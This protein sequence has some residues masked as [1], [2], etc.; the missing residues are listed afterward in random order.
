MM[1]KAGVRLLGIRP[2]MVVA[3]MVAQEVYRANGADLAVTSVIDGT[4]SRASKH[5]TGCGVDL[6]TRHL[7]DPAKVHRELKDALGEDF[8]VILEDDHIHVE[9]DPK[10]PY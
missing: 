6:R 10:S 9:Y 7:Q 1:L 8:D 4:H 3:I 2:E 5:Y